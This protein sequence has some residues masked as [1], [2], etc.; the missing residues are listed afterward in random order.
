ME[1]KGFFIEAGSHDSEWHSIRKAVLIIVNTS[2]IITVD[3]WH[4]VTSK[5]LL[6]PS[7][8]I[9][10]SRHL[11]VHYNNLRIESI[12]TYEGLVLTLFR[13]KQV[14]KKTDIVNELYFISNVSSCI[15]IIEYIKKMCMTKTS[16]VEEKW[17]KNVCIKN[18][19]VLWEVFKTSLIEAKLKRSC[20]LITYCC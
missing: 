1:D 8:H 10:T 14:S 15:I 3:F 5:K 11:Y 2:A 13:W 12:F 16:I 18:F 9:C 20:Y 4:K 17:K 7:I 6:S 19:I